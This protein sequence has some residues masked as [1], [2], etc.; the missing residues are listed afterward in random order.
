MPARGLQVWRINDTRIAVATHRVH[1]QPAP[2]AHRSYV[3]SAAADGG[4]IEARGAAIQVA[5]GAWDAFLWCTVSP[6]EA[7]EVTFHWEVSGAARNQRDREYPFE[8][9]VPVADAATPV[10]F[11]VEGRRPDGSTFR[12]P[13]VTLGAVA[14]PSTARP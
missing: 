10:R 7:R 4:A 2:G 13:A 5:P 12:T 3:V 9:T 14:A 11:S 6:R 8:I 1:P